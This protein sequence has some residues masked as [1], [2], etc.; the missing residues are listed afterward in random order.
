MQLRPAGAQRRGVMVDRAIPPGESYTFLARLRAPAAP[1]RH[2]EEWELVDG[3]GRRIAV[4]GAPT[5]RASIVVPVEGAP[6]TQAPVCTPETARARFVD[7]NYPDDIQVPPRKRFVKRWTVLNTGGCTWSR[8]FRLRYA[9][10]SGERL[11][12]S[13]RE[14]ALE[15]DVPPWSTHTFQ[16]SMQ[17]PRRP[18][19]HREDWAVVEPSGKAIPIS[20]TNVLWAQILVPEHGGP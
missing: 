4:D 1:G 13:R 18:G 19:M 5:I 6:L 12:R 17:A 3:V 20:S 16:V 14:I 10:G 15:E 8:G 2:A 7:E 9:A 11:S